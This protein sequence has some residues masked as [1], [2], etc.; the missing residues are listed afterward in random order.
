MRFPIDGQAAKAL[1]SAGLAWLR[2]NQDSVNA[3]NVY[4]I[5]DGDTG[6]NMVRTMENAF[7]EVADSG[8]RNIGSMVHSIAHGALMGARGNSGVIL[9]QLWRGLARGLD[10][11]QYLDGPGMVKG[12]QEARDTAYRGVV[13][14]VE[15]TILTVAKDIAA[16]SERALEET[17]HPV[18]ILERAVAA[19]DASVKNTP[20]LLPV[21]KNAGV[22][23]AGGMGL[24][25]ILEG[26]LRHINGESLDTP[27]ES[28]RPLHQ[29]EFDNSLEFIEPGQDYEVVVDFR[30]NNGNLG[31]EFF[32]RLEKIGTS[33]QVGEGD[34]MYRFHIHV[35][36]DK[37]YE[38]IDLAI[39]QGTVLKVAIE[40]LVAQMDDLKIPPG[41][42]R[43]ELAPV[44][45]EDIA[46]I[47][48]VPGI[49]FARIFAD[50]GV[51]GLV[52]GGQT[53]N[54]NVHDILDS[55]EGLSTDKV[56]IL[57]NNKNILLAAQGAAELTVKDVQVIPTRTVPQGIAAM[58]NFSPQGDFQTEV[59]RMLASIDE[60]KSATITTAVRSVQ[61]DGIRVK[62]GQ[63]IA[64]LDAGGESRLI[65]SVSTLDESIL[66]LLETAG[67]ADSEIITLYY[68]LD[69]G[70]GEVERIEQKVRAEYPQQEVE[71]H[72]GGQPY[73][74]FIIAIE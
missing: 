70:I 37:R 66:T 48:V 38:P 1:T 30:P 69:I 44:Q 23:D 65:C 22:V 49:G 9:S 15:G 53:M 19:A 5:P 61:I 60:V 43:I 55:F 50:L 73:Y 6:T 28:I 45:S 21:L 33:I 47:A 26:M 24:Y 57:P 62:E 32:G 3:L 36:S 64:I 71:V 72:H 13:R 74:Q 12:F 16:A 68:G 58:L 25:L 17:D 14:P 39:S 46:V 67:A 8:E 63:I 51:A 18:L 56:V 10:G 20:E 2:T 7:K 42:E 54:P 31:K 59:G 27:L 41:F 40:N 35:P 34:G 4:P 29:I 52:E 11:V